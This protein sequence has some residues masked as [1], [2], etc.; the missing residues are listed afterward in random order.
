MAASQMQ[1]QQL[2][3]C[4]FSTCLLLCQSKGGWVQLEQSDMCHAMNISKM[5]IG[6]IFCTAMKDM[7][8]LLKKCCAK[9]WEKRKWGGESPGHR[10]VTAVIEWHPVIVCEN[11]LD[12]YLPCHN[13][14]TKNLQTRWRHKGMGAPPVDWLRQL[15]P[16]QTPPLLHLW[17]SHGSGVATYHLKMM[18]SGKGIRFINFM[19]ALS[20]HK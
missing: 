6:G 15:T 4:T 1:K 19:P 3:S 7:Q 2:I 20:P 14:T 13:G 16:G 10:Q 5:T 17:S 12:G 18:S 8:Y 9:V 11:Q